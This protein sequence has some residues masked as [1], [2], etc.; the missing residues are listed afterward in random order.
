M[1]SEIT[2]L[3][4]SLKV[5]LGVAA[6][7]FA[8]AAVIL[9]IAATSAATATGSMPALAVT[10]VDGPNTGVI[11]PGEQR[12]FRLA[13]RNPQQT[14]PL[15]QSLTLIF[16]PDNGQRVR[17]V[18]MQLFDENQ[19]SLSYDG[20]TQQTANLGA[21]Q[22]VSRDNNPLTGELFWTGWL[23]GQSHY[24]I[25]VANGSD[26]AID[27]WLFTADVTGYPLGQAAENSVVA[28]PAPPDMGA[29]PGAPLALSPGVTRN[30]LKPGETR[31]YTFTHNDPAD[32]SQFQNLAFTLFF[33][34][35]DGNRQQ[36]VNFKL[37][38]VGAVE[39][40]RRGQTN[41]LI[42]FGAGML[43]SRDNNDLTGERLWSGTVIRGE[44]YVL[45]IENGAD[46][47][48][49]YSL[50]EADVTSPAPILK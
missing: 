9:M 30:S 5:F 41:Q 8:A 19:A 38:P 34:P 29:D 33:T 45:A 39:A 36:Q 43:V 21:G 17:Q 42:N 24:Y 10:L 2:T 37:F 44:S 6:A 25:Q 28:V 48:I 16:T 12:W 7:V 32:P 3:P 11:A 31:W 1:R 18:T 49:D 35:N 22:V 47:T 14:T 23:A 20:S 13:L 50:F 46:V 15:E 26:S 27:Y 40:W 4:G